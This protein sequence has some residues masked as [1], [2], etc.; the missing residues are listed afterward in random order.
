MTVP[1]WVVGSGGLLGGALTGVL[2]RRG[3]QPYT[4]R[5][6][7]NDPLGARAVLLTDARR[8]IQSAAGGPWRVAWCAGAGVNGTS[9]EE[10][11]GE[12]AL[13]RAVLDELDAGSGAG[14]AGTV[15]HASS[16]GGV[17]AG[18]PGPPHN[19]MSSVAPL[20]DYGRAK[21]AAEKIVTDF[22]GRSGARVVVGRFANLYGPGQN[23]AKPQGLI[24]HLCRG[25][26]VS[27]PISIYV[28]MDTLRDYVY[29]SD[30]AEMVA[31]T[32][33]RAYLRESRVAT[34]IYASGHSVTIGAILGACRT[35]FRKKPNVVLA[36]S[37]LASTQARDLRLRSVVWDDIDRRTHRTLP[38]GI[39]S[40]LDAIRRDIASS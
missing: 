20:G 31:D 33:D 22:A 28:P 16:A 29:I 36:T 5:V 2:R 19:E 6:P 21:L 40:T 9:M 24:S 7:W 8:L 13:L 27:A 37:A 14:N 35:V 1:T 3:T 30:A 4:S 39:A 38:A 15:F 10:F 23:L 26:L 12:N 32:L 18:S 11:D 34:K 25:Y 17:Y